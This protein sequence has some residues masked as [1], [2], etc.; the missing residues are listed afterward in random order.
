MDPLQ[1]MEAVAGYVS[2]FEGLLRAVLYV[3]GIAMIIL[4]LRLAARRSESGAQ[5]A[6][7]G[8][9][10]SG[11]LT[12]TALL[13]FPATVSVLLSSL[14][15][16]GN[17]ANPE[18]IFALDGGLLDPLS[19]PVARS[20]VSALVMIIQFVGFIAIARGLLLLNLAARP[21]GPRTLG[22]GFTFLIAGALA[23]NFPV[24]FGFVSSL[25]IS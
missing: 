11:F 2:A 21:D 23:V 17:S 25:F 7:S 16:T 24:F 18:T 20:S 5:A 14:F 22:P 15:G 3:M 9:I 13:A 12:G 1:A 10:V 6:P 19:A 8:R 4:S